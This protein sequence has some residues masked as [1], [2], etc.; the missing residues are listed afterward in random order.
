MRTI[1]AVMVGLLAAIFLAV[2]NPTM[3]DFHQ[4]LQTAQKQQATEQ[5]D[6]P[7]VAV[8]K[9]AAWVASEHGKQ[10]ATRKDYVVFSLYSARVEGKT[11]SWV[12]V[13]K[14]F[15]VLN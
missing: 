9:F 12:G 2:T 14:R 8:G 1:G 13:L 11:Y 6:P 15:Y 10:T 5:Q 7:S 3:D 4:Y